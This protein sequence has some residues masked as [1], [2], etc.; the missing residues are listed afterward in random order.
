MIESCAIVLLAVGCTA[1][2]QAEPPTR[3]ADGMSQPE[4]I[5]FGQGVRLTTEVPS[6]VRRSCRSARQEVR[7]KVV[8][9]G[10]VPDVPLVAE[11]GL[12]GPYLFP[13][14]S[15]YLL[16]FN[17]GDIEGTA[18]WIVGGGGVG[19]VRK[20][21]LHGFGNAYPGRARLL[22]TR[23]V[24]SHHVRVYGF[25]EYPAGGAN[26]GHVA[27]L[28]PIGGQVVF[29]SIHGSRWTDAVIAMA[30]ALANESLDAG[31]APLRRELTPEPATYI[32]QPS[33]SSR[34]VPQSGATSPRRS[35]RTQRVDRGGLD[36]PSAM[37]PPSDGGCL[38]P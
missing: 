33:G 25:P 7:V 26:G 32:A 30:V 37:A 35:G 20:W 19:P 6:W 34:P 10:L 8:C 38:L 14:R 4:V 29:A 18:H 27:V 12:S 11:R 28:V 2:D 23:D 31:K 36:D 24:G 5:T 1:V 15:V 22:E 17:N 9:P 13:S 16:S 3:S 21:V